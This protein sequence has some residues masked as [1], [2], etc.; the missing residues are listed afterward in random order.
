LTLLATGTP[1]LLMGDEVR[2]T[3][4]GNNNAYCQNT[5]IA[6]FDWASV[7]KHADIHRVVKRLIAFRMNRDL[8]IERLDM[9]LNELLRRQPFQWHGIRLNAPDWGVQSRS[10]AATVPLL[11]YRL[12]LH[13]IINAYWEALRF[14]IP[15]L[16]AQGRWRRCIDTCCDPPADFCSWADA[17]PV[18]GST[19]LA[20][21]RSVVIL[22]A[23]AEV[24][25]AS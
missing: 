25:A 4:E 9:T 1:M 19:Y 5:E 14:E 3:Q 6:W 13:L 23:N 15:A 11:G 16:E 8:P 7:K 20:Q 21:P 18:P 10:L 2:R 17:P 22:L 12:R 24:E